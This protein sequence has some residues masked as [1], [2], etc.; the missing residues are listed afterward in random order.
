MKL[1]QA[2]ALLLLA[3]THQIVAEGLASLSKPELKTA[4][5]DAVEAGDHENLMAAMEEIR[6]RKMWVF[7]PTASTCVMNVPEL[8]VF[9]QHF[10]NRMHVEQAYQ[11]A[12]QKR[13]LEEGS[14]P[15]MFDWSFSSF[16][17][18]HLGKSPNELT[19]DDVIQLRDWRSQ[20]LSDILGRYT[21]FR[22]ANCQGD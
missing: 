21:E 4:V 15:C 16:V 3:T 13:F 19:Q 12:A 20:E 1:L 14:C 6:R 11:L 8:P 18:G 10:A 5:R 17:L 2:A 9:S 22:N 7:Q